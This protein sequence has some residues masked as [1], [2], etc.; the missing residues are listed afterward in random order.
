MHV[1]N[2]D[3]DTWPR[4]SLQ[5]SLQ[6]CCEAP[7][8]MSIIPSPPAEVPS[9]SLPRPHPPPTLLPLLRRKKGCFPLYI[10]L[11]GK[12]KKKNTK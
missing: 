3:I 2:T 1:L 12:K 4:A 8:A 11:K 5:Y 6:P 9:P 7:E 10:G